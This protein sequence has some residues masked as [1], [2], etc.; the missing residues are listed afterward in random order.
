MTFSA[1]DSYVLF[2]TSKHKDTAKE[3]MKFI[4]TGDAFAKFML[5]IPSHILPAYKPNADLDLYWEDPFIKA[6]IDKV[7]TLLGI[8]EYG[9]SMELEAGAKVVDGKLVQKEGIFNPIFAD[10]QAQRIIAQAVQKHLIEGWTPKAAADWGQDE[11]ERFIEKK[12][13]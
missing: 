12:G 2:E 9:I 6:N 11:I 7:K 1:Y 8:T 13:Y 4:T 10:M 5:T 3:I